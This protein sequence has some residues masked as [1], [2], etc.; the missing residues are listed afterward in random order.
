[1]FVEGHPEP[2]SVVDISH[3]IVHLCSNHFFQAFRLYL[4]CDDATDKA[5]IATLRKEVADW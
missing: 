5:L 4:V 2:V 3:S 1:M